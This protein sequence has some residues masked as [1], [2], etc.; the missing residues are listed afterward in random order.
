MHECFYAFTKR[1]F[2]NNTENNK[3]AS[4]ASHD[5]KMATYQKVDMI[6]VTQDTDP[7]VANGKLSSVKTFKC[8]Y[9]H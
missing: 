4:T 7:H 8:M 3:S 6:V 1:Y 9:H 2:L 5:K